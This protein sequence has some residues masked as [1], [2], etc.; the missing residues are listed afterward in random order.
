MQRNRISLPPPGS[1]RCQGAPGTRMFAA[2][3]DRYVMLHS[4]CAGTGGTV[5]VPRAERGAA[6]PGRLRLPARPPHHHPPPRPGLCLRRGGTERRAVR[7]I[8]LRATGRPADRLRRPARRGGRRAPLPRQVGDQ[9]GGQRR[10]RSG[11]RQA[12]GE[13]HRRELAGTQRRSGHPTALRLRSTGSTRGDP[14][15]KVLHRR[16]R[17]RP[18]PAPT[19]GSPPASA[20]ASA[21]LC[22]SRPISCRHP[23]RVVPVLKFHTLMPLTC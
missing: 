12:P 13:A 10:G 11:L 4:T 6:C 7:H 5:H 23:E 1:R 16:R 19:G 9:R 8:G 15:G 18:P 17:C 14:H 22:L 3:C 20:R 2:I 21:D